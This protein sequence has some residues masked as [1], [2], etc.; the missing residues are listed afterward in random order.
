MFLLEIFYK[1]IF[2][3]LLSNELIINTLYELIVVNIEQC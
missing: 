2:K 1:V 3:D